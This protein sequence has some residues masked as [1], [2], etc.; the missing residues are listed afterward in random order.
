VGVVAAAG[1]H[2]SAKRKV[3]GVGGGGRYPRLVVDYKDHTFGVIRPV[4]GTSLNEDSSITFSYT[5][6]PDQLI[7]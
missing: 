4:P 2:S 1:K 6:L 5:V 3:E 7:R